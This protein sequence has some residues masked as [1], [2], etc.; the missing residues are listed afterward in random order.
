M[1][2]KS[3]SLMAIFYLVFCLV[4]ILT[5]SYFIDHLLIR[6]YRYS[7]YYSLLLLIIFATTSYCS[8]ISNVLYLKDL[9]GLLL[10]FISCLVFYKG[11]FH[12]KILCPFLI[13]LAYIISELIILILVTYIFQMNILIIT[14]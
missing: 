12:Y 6:K 2:D 11:P 13:F 5:F 9:L 4:N 14:I 1:L 10:V 8:F 3:Q 7:Y